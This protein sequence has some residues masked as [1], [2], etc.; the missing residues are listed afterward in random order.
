MTVYQIHISCDTCGEVETI[1][2]GSLKRLKF[3]EEA[4]HTRLENDGWTE[5][6]KKHHCPNCKKEEK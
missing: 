1:G 5:D 2:F 4:F 3:L 6:E